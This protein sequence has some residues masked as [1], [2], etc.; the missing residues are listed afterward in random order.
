MKSIVLATCFLLLFFTT[1]QGSTAQNNVQFKNGLAPIHLETYQNFI[2]CTGFNWNNK[3][4]LSVYIKEKTDTIFTNIT[5]GIDLGLNVSS[6]VRYDN[7]GTIWAFGRNNLWK[8]DQGQWDSVTTPPDLLPNRYFQDFRFDSDNNLIV[9]VK[10]YFESGRQNSQGTVLIY[11]DSTHNELLKITTNNSAVSYEI[12]KKYYQYEQNGNGL[13]QSITKRND[14]AVAV[15]LREDTNNVL[16]YKDGIISYQTAIIDKLQ[17]QPN[18]TSMA[19]D[20]E[21]NLWVSVNSIDPLDKRNH[22]GLYKFT[23]TNTFRK[24]DS[25]AGLAGEKYMSI[26][27]PGT[28]GVN[29]VSSNHETG[30]IWCGTDYGFFSVD[31]TKP[32]NEQVAF[33]TRD[34]LDNQYKLFRYGG[35]FDH[36]L[37][38][39]DITFLEEARYFANPL[40]LIEYKKLDNKTTVQNEDSDLLLLQMNLYPI[41]SKEENLT[42]S[43]DNVG[44]VNEATIKI[45]DALGN[46]KNTMKIEGFYGKIEIPLETKELSSGMYNVIFSIGAN[47]Y[48]KQFVVIK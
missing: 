34:S 37:K 16:L 10:R 38:V 31:E 1:F 17:N 13:F 30:L 23:S 46:R 39:T 11:V 44:F 36:P 41:P 20:R 7:N 33:Y 26:R 6:K 28:L 24:W 32:Q 27:Y 25:S 14:G 19:Y 8:Y 9:I 47:V 3:G 12:L 29:C 22:N 21:M 35:F 15:Y 45:V 2:L 40:A 48:S 18:I 5:E 43:I 4:I 42:L